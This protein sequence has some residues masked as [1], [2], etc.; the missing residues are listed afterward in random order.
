MIPVREKGTKKNAR[1][2]TKTKLPTQLKTKICTI[3]GLPG[4]ETDIKSGRGKLVLCRVHRE[5]TKSKENVY[6]VEFVRASSLA[7]E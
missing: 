3:C 1:F 4:I 5:L 6:K 7:S 2:S